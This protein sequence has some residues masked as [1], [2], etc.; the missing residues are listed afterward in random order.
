ML[1]R[2]PEEPVLRTPTHDH[3]PTVATNHPSLPV[4]ANVAGS[5]SL[6]LSLSLSLFT[7]IHLINMTCCFGPC[8]SY[9]AQEMRMIL[10]LLEMAVSPK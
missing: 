4:V 8:C 7:Y 9:P 3:P 2:D 1:I 5:P 10:S 6:S